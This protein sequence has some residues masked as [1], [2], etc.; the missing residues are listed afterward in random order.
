MEQFLSSLHSGLRWIVLLMLLVA[1][2]TA[3]KRWKDGSGFGTKGKLINLLTL[4]SV[5]LQLVVGLVLYFISPKVS[6]DNMFANDMYRFYTLEHLA[7]MVLSIALI[8]IGYSQAKK[9]TTPKAKN[10]KTFVFFGI[11]LLIILIAIPWPFRES[12]GAGWF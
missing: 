6:L 3:F 1:I 2:I 12:L 5:H 8:T 11:G 7:M 9:A 4:A 10:R